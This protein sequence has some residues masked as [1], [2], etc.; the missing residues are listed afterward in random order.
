MKLSSSALLFLFVTIALVF[1]LNNKMG[2]LPPLGK[3]LDPFHGFWQQAESKDMETE[4]MIRLNGLKGKV[5][6]RFDENRIPHIEAENEEDLYF[7]QGYIIARDRLWQLDFQTRFAAGRLSEVIGEKAIDLDKYNRRMG[8]G[9][10]ARN[11]EAFV[12][13]D[14]KMKM[15]LDAYSNGINA[16]IASL[17]PKDYPI[18]FKLLDYQPELWKPINS[19]YLLKL[20]SSTLA[21]ASNDFYMTNALK[22]F[23]PEV[24][25]DLFPNYPFREDPIIPVG[26]QWDFNPITVP[27]VPAETI[28]KTNIKLSAKEEGLGSNNWAISGDRTRSGYPILANDPHLEMTLPAIWYQNQ[29]TAP[30]VN[31][32]GVTIPGSPGV[33]IGFN[34][35]VAWGVTNVGSD[36]L[37]WYKITFRNHERNEY[38][39]ENEW[40]PIKKVI[41]TIQIRGKKSVFD[42]VLYTHYG[43]I[44]YLEGEKPQ[45]LPKSNNVPVGYAIKWIAHQASNDIKTFYELNRAKNYADYQAALVHYVAPAQNFIFASKENDIGITPNGYFPLKWK[46]QG[47]FL[48]DGKIKA[49]DWQGRIPADHNPTVKNPKRGFVSSANQFSADT[50]YPYYLHWEFSGY[51]RGARINRELA[52]MENAE[53]EDF[54]KLQNDNYSIHAENVRDILVKHVMIS[55]LTLREKKALELMQKW[56]LKYE[57]DEIPPSIF[58]WWHKALALGIWSDEFTDDLFPMA[59]PSRDRTVALLYSEEPSKWFDDIKT[60]TIESKKDIVTKTFKQTIDSLYKVYGEIG[61]KW[62]WG[63]VKGTNIPHLAKISGFGTGILYTGGSKTSVNAISQ[64]TGPSWRMIV[65]LGKQVEGYGL[66]PGGQSGNPGSFFYDNMVEKWT[67]GQLNKLYFYEKGNTAAQ[68]ITQTLSLETKN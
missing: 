40:K 47:K 50:T 18:E 41:E 23:G 56:S 29:L 55:K 38:L 42:T 51:E 13:K 58:E 32:Y 37:D 11:M 60:E 1:L 30:G 54:Q 21:S 62:A 46:G 7:A 33:I 44:V 26:T 10:G 39:V 36:V 31:V 14:P 8:M 4:S 9:L 64:T 25:Q 59:M 3:F 17:K 15:V 52:K 2:P 35:D 66:F 68:K 63:H 57:A 20:M 16:Y 22:K 6:I 12:S 24:I 45:A 43:P 34:K 5:T 27:A 49:H 61:T 65:A 67:A 48:L 19:A 28:E 53:I